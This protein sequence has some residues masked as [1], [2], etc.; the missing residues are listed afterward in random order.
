MARQNKKEFNKEIE[1]LLPP[2]FQ[3]I[4]PEGDIKKIEHW[5]SL[6][7]ENE[8]I[9][10]N[11]MKAWEGTEHLKRMYNYNVAKA[12][13]K[14][15]IRLKKSGKQRMASFLQKAAA[16][17]ILPF[18]ISTLYLGIQSN[19]DQIAQDISWHTIKTPVGIRSEYLLPDG[20]KVY[21]NS[22]SSL[23]YPTNFS[24]QSRKVALNGEAY[25]E[26][27]EN[28]NNPFIVNTGKIQIEVTGTTFKASNYP[29]EKLT[30]IVLV[31]GKVNLFQ[32]EDFKLNESLSSLN[33]GERASYYEDENKIYVDKVNV[34]KYISWK[35]GILMFRDDSMKE[36]VR[37][38]NRWF[39]VDIQLKGRELTDYVYTATFEDESLNQILE[40]LKISAPIDYSISRREKRADNTFSKMEVVITRL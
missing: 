14:V 11:S 12:L 5:K 35:D 16:I 19:T 8:Q 40:L 13:S 23:S 9:F 15:N 34:Q 28:K 24:G 26:V 30:E 7:V 27:A 2:Y 36:I 4:L 3:G 1:C 18:I 29:E 20:T 39:N 38:L 25:F 32:G 10:T 17:L 37:R 6:S 21:L 22:K 33:P 31:S